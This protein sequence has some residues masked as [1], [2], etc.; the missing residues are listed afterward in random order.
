MP[1]FFPA[2]RVMLDADLPSRDE[3]RS[4]FAAAGLTPRHREIVTEVVA[5]D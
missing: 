1:N 4:N 3:I 5:P 2:V